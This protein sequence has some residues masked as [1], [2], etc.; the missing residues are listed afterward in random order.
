MNKLIYIADDDLNICNLLKTS[1][2]NEN[3]NVEVFFDGKKLLDAFVSKPCD[4]ILTDIMMPNMNG[5]ELCRNIRKLSNIPIIMLS[6]KDEEIDK[7]LGLELGSDD[8]LSKPFSLR[9][10]TIK[11]KNILR[12]TSSIPVSNNILTS[13]NLKL[14]KTNREIFINDTLFSTTTKEYNLLELL[15]EN[16]NKAFSREVIINNVWGYD[17]YGDTRQVDHLIKRLRKKMLLADSLC[18]IETI[19]GFGY[20]VTD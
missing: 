19:W 4:I 12:R 9:E 5:Y 3:Y 8:Y 14:N 16:K 11:V 18:K 10:V 6:A 15:I 2:V 13:K 20:K 1:L 7:I 17:Y